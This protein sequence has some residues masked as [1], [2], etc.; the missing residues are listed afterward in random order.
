MIPAVEDD[1]GY[2]VR[3]SDLAFL[4]IS[5]KSFCD[6]AKGA[7]PLGLSWITYDAFK[8]RLWESIQ[9]DG[10]NPDGVDV[11][12]KGSS[13]AFF[14]GLH[15]EL[16][17]GR[18]AIVFCWRNARGWRSRLPTEFEVD[19][20][21]RIFAEVWPE[22]WPEGLPEVPP[23]PSRPRRRP[24]D[25]MYRLGIEREPS[26]Y[27]LQI[28]SDSIVARCVEAVR[29]LGVEPLREA[30]HHDAYNFIRKD[31]LSAA[32]PHLAQYSIL[33]SDALRRNVGLAVF[34][35]AGPPDVSEQY[36]ELSS[37]FKES[38]WRIEYA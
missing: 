1:S 23:G 18:A 22:A 14:S 7:I 26:D 11:R 4:A 24:Y 30:T 13:T 15:K 8:F 35:S 20:I 12:L 16:P 32:M 5:E 10:V 25:S 9:A 34:E 3:L 27:D 21:E 17:L 38:D 33:M 29:Q 6:R 2:R 28:S 36:G 37:H 31:I 19:E